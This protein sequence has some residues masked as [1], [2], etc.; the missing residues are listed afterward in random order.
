M[1]GNSKVTAIIKEGKQQIIKFTVKDPTYLS[2]DWGG[3]SCIAD[4][5]I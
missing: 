5:T 3:K 4:T 2:S 1:E